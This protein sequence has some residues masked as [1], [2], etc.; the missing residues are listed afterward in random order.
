MLNHR[1]PRQTTWSYTDDRQGFII[2]AMEDIKRGE[3]V[4]DSYGK[5]CN[6]RFFLNYGFINLNNDANE[7]PFK[8][9]Y[10]EDDKYIQL[11]KEMIG[12]DA[13][14]KKFRILASYD[15]R[16]VH[17]FLSWMRFVLYDEKITLLY[18]YKGM[19]IT[20]AQKYKQR[21]ADS[22]SDDEEDYSKGF[23]A[24]DLPPLSINNEKKV[25]QKIYDMSV[26]AMNKYPTS[27]EEDQEI[28]KR[29]DLTFNQSNSVLY[30]AGEKEILQFFITTTSKF[31]QLFDMKWKDARKTA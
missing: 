1:R 2:E 3:Q 8:V 12:D 19:A 11:K 5:K 30:R 6:Y 31:M 27:Y 10:E 21:H 29:T 15:E 7:F 14:F 18:E 25:L 26:E 24:K 9:Y 23:K 20:A 4:Y 17:E 13:D 16:I 28:L 22:D